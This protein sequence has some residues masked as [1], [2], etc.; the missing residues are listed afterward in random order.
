MQQYKRK[1][2]DLDGFIHTTVEAIQLT[3]DNVTEVADWCTGKEV[4]EI[5]ALDPKKSYVGLNFLSWNG[6]VRASE[7]DYIIRDALGGFHYMWPQRFEENFEKVEGI[8]EMKKPTLFEQYQEGG[9]DG[10]SDEGRDHD[11]GRGSDVPQLR[12]P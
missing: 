2:P 1:L 5:D 7:G 4:K 6:I 11:R 9:L 8:S 12:R 3:H 10:G